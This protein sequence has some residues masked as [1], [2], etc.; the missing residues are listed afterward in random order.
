MNRKPQ[1]PIEAYDHLLPKYKIWQIPV[2]R[3]RHLT[4]DDYSLQ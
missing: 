1:K 2:N 4:A 3:N